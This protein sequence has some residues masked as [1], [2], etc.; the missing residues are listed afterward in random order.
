IC[1]PTVISTLL[2][3]ITYSM[4]FFGMAYHYSQW[5]FVA[6]VVV[7]LVV[8]VGQKGGVG[9]EESSDED[10]EGGGEAERQPLVA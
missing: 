7:G 1:T 5:V 10:E 6:V 3:K 8:A 2:H 9:G 4:P